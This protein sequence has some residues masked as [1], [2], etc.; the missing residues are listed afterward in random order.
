MFISAKIDVLNETLNARK[1]IENYIGSKRSQNCPLCKSA[2]NLRSLRSFTTLSNF[3]QKAKKLEEAFEKDL[4]NSK[5]PNS[6]ISSTKVDETPSQSFDRDCFQI[7]ANFNK[8][9]LFQKTRKLVVKT[10]RRRPMRQINP[11]V[12]KRENEF[13]VS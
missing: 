10:N 11:A 5:L 8:K 2:V 3:V 4:S 9:G 12:R 7:R 6:T 1:C 13:K